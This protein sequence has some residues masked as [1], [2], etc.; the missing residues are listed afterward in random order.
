MTSNKKSTTPSLNRQPGKPVVAHL[1]TGISAQSVKRPVPPPVYRPKTTTPNAAQPK[2]ANGALNRK[3]PVAPPVFRPQVVPRVLQTKIAVQPKANS[4]PAKIANSLRP[5]TAK[6][7]ASSF[8]AVQLADEQRNAHEC[9]AKVVAAGGQGYTGDYDGMHAEINA[10]EAY[11]ASGGDTAGIKRIELSSS[12]CQYCSIILS[13][14]GIG[15]KVVTSDQRKYGRCQGGSYGW[16][17][18]AG[19]LWKAIKLA[20]GADDEDEYSKSV[21]SRVA[22]LK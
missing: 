10:L 6:R 16:F 19:S 21:C 20:T 12:P 11:F 18:R 22:K 8:N 5:I 13:D 4:Q 9:S 15:H 14:L 2:M 3:L 7:T 1:K 17:A